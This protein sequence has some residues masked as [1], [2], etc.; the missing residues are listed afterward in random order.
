[1]EGPSSMGTWRQFRRF[2]IIGSVTSFYTPCNKKA[3]GLL[4][5]VK[6]LHKDRKEQDMIREIVDVIVSKKTYN[7]SFAYSALAKVVE[8][9]PNVRGQ[10]L[11]DVLPKICANIRDVMELLSYL[12]KSWGRTTKRAIENWML[13]FSSHAMAW[14]MTRYRQ[15]CG[16]TVQD[17]LRLV[18]PNPHRGAPNFCELFAYVAD[19][20]SSDSFSESTKEFHEYLEDLEKVRHTTLTDTAVT[21]IQKHKLSFEHVGQS[22]L[23]T[24]PAVWCSLIQNMSSE[25]LVSHLSRILQVP[26]IDTTCVCNAISAKHDSVHP[27]AWFEALRSTQHDAPTCVDVHHALDRAFHR[28]LKNL[29]PTLLQYMLAIDVS[30]SMRCSPCHGAPGLSAR[31]AAAAIATCFLACEPFVRVTAFSDIL[32]TLHLYQGDSLQ[33]VL[34]TI[35]HLS[36]DSTDC[37]LPMMYA[38]EHNIQVDCFVIITDSETSCYTVAPS[39]ILEKYRQNVNPYAKLVVVATST[40]TVGVAQP[41]NRNM[42][43]I[44]GMDRHVFSL[45]QDFAS[46]RV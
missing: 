7:R 26:R 3:D 4:R 23:L 5:C 42:L 19:K 16:F 36:F 41:W 17:I 32:R 2:L 34:S 43:D 39:E 18:H 11:W 21:L 38:L 24:E 22:D 8:C 10:V 12:P 9:A 29:E 40:E 30:G 27:L 1:M 35:S 14:Q 31:D 28:S 20:W 13:S 25:E 33:T 45:I 15:Q 46:G 6:E 37:S 44:A